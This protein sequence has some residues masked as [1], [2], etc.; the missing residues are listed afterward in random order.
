MQIGKIENE[1]DLMTVCEGLFGTTD[2][3]EWHIANNTAV[4]GGFH[5]AAWEAGKLIG[6]ADCETDGSLLQSWSSR[7]G[8]AAYL[9]SGLLTRHGLERQ[10][11]DYTSK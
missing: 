10:P 9:E 3:W 8:V 11:E 6:Y 2:E 1:V 5:I 4:N 7:D